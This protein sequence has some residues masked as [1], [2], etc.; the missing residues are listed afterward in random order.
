MVKR[1]ATAILV[2]MPTRLKRR[3]VREVARRGRTLNDVAVALVAERYG[4]AFE[5]SGHRSGASPGE[6]PSVLLRVP[7]ALRERLRAVA[8]E[9]ATSV[10]AIVVR[11]LTEG[12]AIENPRRKDAMTHG[13]G[14]Q[15]GRARSNGK[16][17][18]A[19]VGVGNCA[20]ALVQGVE[21]YRDAPADQFVPGLMHVDLGGYHVGDVE[22]TAAF[23]VNA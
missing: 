17:R 15:N 21:Y 3:L 18:V 6:S 10:N 20:N 1:D 12:L 19:L 8:D 7:V 14:R 13:N 11:A 4:V 16:V 2:R 9:Q 5:P 22:F 23:D